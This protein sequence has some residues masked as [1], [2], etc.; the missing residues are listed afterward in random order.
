MP[1]RY[2]HPQVLEELARRRVVDEQVRELRDYDH[3]DEV[4]EQ[5]KPGRTRLGVKRAQAQT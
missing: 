5:P 2:E 1:V 3:E 4:E